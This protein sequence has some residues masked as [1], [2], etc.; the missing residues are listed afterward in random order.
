[1]T[2]HFLGGV[3]GVFITLYEYQHGVLFQCS[4]KLETNLELHAKDNRDL[5][6]LQA[7]RGPLGSVTTLFAVVSG[8]GVE[9]F[10]GSKAVQAAKEGSSSRRGR[11]TEL[12]LL[13]LK[14]DIKTQ[15]SYWVVGVGGLAAFV[16]HDAAAQFAVEHLVEE[17]VAWLFVALDMSGGG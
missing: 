5:A 10:G 7:L 1:V 15:I 3:R 17:T 13:M 14:L 2:I 11:A 8:V 4:Q 6:D 12:A 9:I 16:A